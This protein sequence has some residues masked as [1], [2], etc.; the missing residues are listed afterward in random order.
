MLSR[1]KLAQLLLGQAPLRD[2]KHA[3]IVLYMHLATVDTA[4]STSVNFLWLC[5]FTLHFCTL[6]SYVHAYQ[7]CSILQLHNVHF[8]SNV[9]NYFIPDTVSCVFQLQ[10]LTILTSFPMSSLHTP[11]V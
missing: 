4:H 3:M 7:L 6:C 9:V 8:H 1:R 5:H 10:A 11:D 2:C